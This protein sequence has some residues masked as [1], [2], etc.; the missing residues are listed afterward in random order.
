MQAASRKFDGMA[1]PRPEQAI[2]DEIAGLAA[3]A[4]FAH[5][6]AH[7]CARDNFTW[8]RDEMRAEDMNHLYSRSRLIRTEMTTLIGLM[9]RGGRKVD[10]PPPAEPDA[11]A[12]RAEDLLEELHES[13][14]RPWADHFRAAVGDQA[15]RD[16][17][18]TG[19]ALREPIFYG[20]EAAFPFQYCDFAAE[21]YAAD[22]PWL[23]TN[24]GASIGEMIAVAKAITELQT[25]KMTTAMR[26][27]HTE[28][29]DPRLLA[30]FVFTADELEPHV[31]LG[32]G[33]IGECIRRFT[34]SS[35]DGNAAF[36]GLHD[37]NVVIGAPIIALDEGRH[38]LF[39]SN[40]LAEALYESPFYWLAADVGYAPVSFRNRG[41]YTE[42][43]ALRRLRAVFGVE[44]VFRRVN[45]ERRKGE[46][47]G[48]IDILVVFG[49]RAIVLQA[50]S[51]RLSM[52]SRRGNDL[53]LKGDFK[54]AVQDAYNQALD[55]AVALSDRT[56][57]FTA[58]DGTD[59]DVPVDL[60]Q[61]L[62]IC[63]V[64]DNYPALAFQTG[65]FLVR[66]DEPRTM[67]AL[68]IDVFTLD[69]MAEMLSRPLRFL[70]Y[71]ELRAMHGVKVSM[72]HEMTLLSYHL[73]YNLWLDNHYDFVALDDD[74]A[75]D[76]EIAM[77]ARRLGLPGRRTPTGILTAIGGRRLDELIL[78]MEAEPFGPMID[79]V[80]LIYQLSGRSL[81]ALAEGVDRVVEGA[82]LKGSSDFTLG[83][84]G[85]G[86]TVHANHYDQAEAEHRLQAHMTLR[87]YSRKA[88][89]WFGI[90]LVPGSGEIRFCYKVASPWTFDAE[91]EHLLKQHDKSQP[92]VRSGRKGT[93]PDRND[94]CP[95]GSGAKYKKCHLAI[96]VRRS[97]TVR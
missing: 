60:K 89:E 56:L 44:R 92:D 31:D 16:P 67:E 73:K 3:T 28:I 11:V 63:L 39:H 34:T 69:A 57:R 78:K 18:R 52:A 77:G 40:A 32:A 71:L 7:F 23:V 10:G 35:A 70:S 21:K 66:R 27:G 54:R 86:L 13:M 15:P 51:K 96:D 38:L 53:Q 50:K 81:E 85:T 2:F 6:L 5:V 95:C 46:R 61:I 90:C 26:E 83:L 62:P 1:P 43:L 84:A 45:I 75:A 20:G 19:D 9:V 25:A 14:M 47:L 17:W 49:D 74:F 76:L 97:R 42:A 37:Y 58:E 65:Q 41:N 24:T 93:T 22:D 94:P 88:D 82:R 55:C 64:A 48:E 30:A 59:V 80:M 12:S 87:K 72:S 79:L 91:V 68:V 29:G 8:Y 33:K 36:R 4:G